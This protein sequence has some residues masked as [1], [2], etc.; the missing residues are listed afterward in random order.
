MWRSQSGQRRCCE[1]VGR[2]W[3]LKKTR[4]VSILRVVHPWIKVMRFETGDGCIIATS[5]KTARR[6]RR[7]RRKRSGS[8]VRRRRLC[9][10][11]FGCVSLIGQA[12]PQPN[13]MLLASF[14]RHTSIS[15]ERSSSRLV[16]MSVQTRRMYSSPLFI[17]MG[18]LLAGE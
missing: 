11:C 3:W 6:Q 5:C 10:I 2:Q 12:L 18:L 1:V 8:V 13:L 4:A 7:Q 9:T 16:E 14:Y 15:A 17:L